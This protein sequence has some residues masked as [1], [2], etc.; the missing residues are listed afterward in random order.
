[1]K[2]LFLTFSAFQNIKGAKTFVSIYSRQASGRRLNT[3][4]EDNAVPAAAPTTPA[5]PPTPDPGVLA[6]ECT[7]E[8][9]FNNPRDCRK[10]FWCLDSGPANLGVVAHAFT[11]PS[12]RYQFE[13]INPPAHCGQSIHPILI[14]EIACICFMFNLCIHLEEGCTTFSR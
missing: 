9:F 3:D 5:P 11:C 2:N 14:V 7:D 6:F 8:G 4:A 13:N 12:G 1:M 10:Y